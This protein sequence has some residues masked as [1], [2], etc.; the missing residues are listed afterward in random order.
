MLLVAVEGFTPEQAA[1]IL[2]I[3]LDVLRC[4]L[5]HARLLIGTART[6]AGDDL[7]APAAAPTPAAPDVE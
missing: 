7:H 1:T 5:A 3:P 4:R 2:G 6:D